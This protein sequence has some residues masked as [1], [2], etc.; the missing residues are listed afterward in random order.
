MANDLTAVCL[1]P[2]GREHREPL[3]GDGFEGVLGLLDDGELL[4]LPLFG[5]VDPG[6]DQL[7]GVFPTVAGLLD[8]HLRIHAQGEVFRRTESGSDWQR[9][10]PFYL[11]GLSAFRSTSEGSGECVAG[12]EWWLGRDSNPRPRRYECHALTS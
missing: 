8:A 12:G 2:S 1:H 10:K 11:Q 7:P 5:W 6:L 3:A 9:L 4:R